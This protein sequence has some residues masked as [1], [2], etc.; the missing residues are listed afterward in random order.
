MKRLTI[1]LA[2]PVLL[3]GCAGLDLAKVGDMPAE[4]VCSKAAKIRA[5]AETARRIADTA[6]TAVDMI[7]P[8]AAPL[9]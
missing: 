7:C 3:A 1:A 5:A 9:E 2:L 8:F 6:E 4:T